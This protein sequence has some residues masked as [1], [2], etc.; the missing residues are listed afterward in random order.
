MASPAAN[1]E[2][3]LRLVDQL[4][5]KLAELGDSLVLAGTKRKAKIHIHVDDPEVVFDTARLFGDVHDPDSEVSEAIRENG[6]YQLMPEWGT[7]PANWRGSNVPAA[8]ARNRP[9]SRYR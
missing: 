2:A 1:R 9:G 7:Q 4:R 5:E 3:H 8:S 6:G